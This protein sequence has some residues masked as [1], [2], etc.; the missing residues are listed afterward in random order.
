MRSTRR[1]TKRRMFAVFAV[2]L[3]TLLVGRAAMASNSVTTS[4]T[5]YGT[6]T[7]SGATVQ[8][9]SYTLS[10]DGTTI[11]GARLALVGD[12]TGR[13]IAVGFNAAS[14]TTCVNG[15]YVPAA[16]LTTVTCTGLSQN[17]NAALTLA[18]S[19]NQ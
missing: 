9:V 16:N 10:A 13:A 17:N 8:S 18:V 19:V 12:L 6:G 1:T 14:L 2:A 5:G 15:A 3:L 7:V 4:S 11:T